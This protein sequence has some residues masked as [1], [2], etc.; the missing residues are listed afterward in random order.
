MANQNSLK[1]DYIS[2]E[3]DY[4]AEELQK[5]LRYSMANFA[6]IRFKRAIKLRISLEESA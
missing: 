2:P 1:G 3:L 5:K 6:Q 4:R